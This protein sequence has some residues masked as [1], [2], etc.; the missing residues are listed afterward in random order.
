MKVAESPMFDEARGSIA[1]EGG[2]SSA[3]PRRSVGVGLLS[4]TLEGLYIG[5]RS[6]GYPA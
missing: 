4:H 6:E 2:K 1:P 5:L 3:G